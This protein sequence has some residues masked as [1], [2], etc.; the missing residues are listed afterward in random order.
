MLYQKTQVKSHLS[1]YLLPHPSGQRF[2]V[3]IR[4]YS[5]TGPTIKI[6]HSP[7]SYFYDNDR[8]EKKK[9]GLE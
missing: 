6:K 7:T 1:L 8:T 2:S 5:K 9:L 3:P 4:R